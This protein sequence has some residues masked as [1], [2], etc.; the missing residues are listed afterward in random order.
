MWKHQIGCVMQ[1]L[2]NRIV[3]ILEIRE[4]NRNAFRRNELFYVAFN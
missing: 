3:Y 1:F 4:R 2:Q